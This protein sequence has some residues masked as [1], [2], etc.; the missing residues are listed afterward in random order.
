VVGSDAIHGRLGQEM[1]YLVKLGASESQ[2]IIAA[3]RDAARVCGLEQ[4]IGTLEPGKIA[5]IIAVEGNP[6]KDIGVLKRLKLS[7][8]GEGFAIPIKNGER[9]PWPLPK[10]RGSERNRKIMLDNSP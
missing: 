3:T 5:D 8:A 2:A 4:D 1:E 6:L 7:S 10:A 9:P